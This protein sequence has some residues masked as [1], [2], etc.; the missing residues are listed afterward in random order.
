MTQAYFG[1]LDLL[2]CAWCF[3]AASSVD[4]NRAYRDGY[5]DGVTLGAERKGD[6]QQLPALVMTSK[7][8]NYE[9]ERN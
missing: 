8:D 6:D 2:L 7:V 9:I 1:I 5:Y 4:S 3:A